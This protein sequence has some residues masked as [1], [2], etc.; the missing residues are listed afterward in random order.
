METQNAD[1]TIDRERGSDVRRV[2]TMVRWLLYLVFVVIG[3][4]I[5]RRLAPV[6][7][8]LLAAA[9]IAYLL[10]PLCDRAEERGMPRV[11][12]V[13]LLLGGFTAIITVALVFLVPL[14]AEDVSRFVADLPDL[15]DKT[16]AWLANT[17]G[18]EVPASW[19]DYL[20]EDELSNVL[21][22]AAVPLATMATAALGGF[23]SFLGAI[24]ELL[25][26]PVFAFYLLL[27]WNH[28]VLRVRRVVP[29]RHR[30]GVEDVV[31]EVDS[32]VSSWLRGQLIVTSILAVLYAVA[33][34]IIG[35]H[36]AIPVG[37]MVGLLTIIPFL[38]TIVGAI[39]TAAI[40]LVDWQG[41]GQIIAVGG[42][43]GV[44]HVLEAAVLT[45][46]IVGHRVGLGEVGAL[47]AVLAGGKLLGFAGV[48]LAV[49]IAASVAVIVRRV[50]RYYEGSSFFTEGAIPAWTSGATDVV[51]DAGAAKADAAARPARD[52]TPDEP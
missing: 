4:L 34:Q 28:I 36:L 41:P 14:V 26:I 29:Q 31:S 20:S 8:P 38:G 11:A 50:V 39:I 9:G 30:A 3:Y 19:R 23:F 33:F 25:L 42:V 48:L 6:L 16:T 27:D 45:P 7:T 12:A 13:A 24:A 10:D 18:F 22:E 5:L 46:K 1:S 32:V 43:F 37:A 49:P 47:F 21:R 2:L 35:I 17:F 44:L 51:G 15:I 52:E 40:V